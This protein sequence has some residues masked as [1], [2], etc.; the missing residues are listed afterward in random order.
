MLL[1]CTF[2]GVKCHAGGISFSGRIGRVGR[3][4]LS[5]DLAILG[6]VHF[7]MS[8]TDVGLRPYT[9]LDPRNV[10]TVFKSKHTSRSRYGHPQ[11]ILRYIAS[12]SRCPR[13]PSI[14]GPS[15]Y[16]T[17][18]AV[19]SLL[20]VASI[21]YEL[22]ITVACGPRSVHVLADFFAPSLSF[23][24]SSRCA[25]HPPATAPTGEFKR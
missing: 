7:G 20:Q 15:P 14:R 9:V 23:H 16:P 4:L 18:R 10:F 8:W 5:G 17:T 6:K 11:H 25:L 2:P 24:T 22:V 1:I 19:S 3:G 12:F 21:L 13:P